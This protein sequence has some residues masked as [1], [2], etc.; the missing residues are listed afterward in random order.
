MVN[1]GDFYLAPPDKW[2][3]GCEVERP[4]YYKGLQ[5]MI[6]DLIF[7]VVMQEISRQNTH[8]NRQPGYPKSEHVAVA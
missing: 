7:H 8:Y 6:L 5:T 4:I 1:L 3:Q 2:M